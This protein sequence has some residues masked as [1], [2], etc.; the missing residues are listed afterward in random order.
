MI[1]LRPIRTDDI[2][3]IKKWPPYSGGF[4]QMDYA[5]RENGWLDEFQNRP[6]TWLYLAELNEQVIGFSLL[7]ATSEEEAEFRIAIH[8]DWTG[9]GAGRDVTLATLNMGFRKL[10]L[11]KIH[12]IVR[13]NNPRAAR[14]YESIGFATTG[15]SVHSI[16]GKDIAFIDMDMTKEQFNNLKAALERPS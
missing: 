10:G 2:A 8:P 9:R 7:S 5:L 14:L 15:G 16:Q 12:L 11:S 3:E 6:G 1:E 4:E 13:E